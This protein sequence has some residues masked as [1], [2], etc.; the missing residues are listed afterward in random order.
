[1]YFKLKEKE[2]I[3][4]F[5]AGIVP[6]IKRDFLMFILHLVLQSMFQIWSVSEMRAKTKKIA[7]KLAGKMINACA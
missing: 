3:S 5:K 1:M 7:N 6:N 2:A 4:Y